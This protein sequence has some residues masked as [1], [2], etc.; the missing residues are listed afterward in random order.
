MSY[1]YGQ[2][3]WNLLMQDIKNEFGVAGLMGNL[4]AESNLEPNNLQNSYNT[5][6]GL[7]D[8]DYTS[9]VDNGTYTNFVYDEAGYGLAQW[10]YYIRK[11]ALYNYKIS[12]GVSIA[13]VTMQVEFLISELKSS[14]SDVYNSLISATNIR[15]PSNKVLH[16]FENPAIQNTTVEV[17]RESLGIEIYNL[18]SGSQITPNT[19][20]RANIKKKNFKFI[21]FNNRRRRIW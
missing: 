16:D 11:Q 4:V 13:D 15:T 10:T 18:Y 2:Q 12:K 21:L 9:G 19:P 8:V 1:T 17:Y 14:Y 20:I 3:I 5:S 6:L 7:T